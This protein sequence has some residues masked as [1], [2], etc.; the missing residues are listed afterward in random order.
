MFIIIKVF[1]IKVTLKE[2]SFAGNLQRDEFIQCWKFRESILQI[3]CNI[4][5][6]SAQKER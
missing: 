3:L 2:N 6:S 4:L 1:I 5:I